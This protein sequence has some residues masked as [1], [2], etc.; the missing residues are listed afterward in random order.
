MAIRSP[1]GAL[2]L[3]VAGVLVPGFALAG[4]IS[5]SIA[6]TVEL[7]DG[8]LAATVQVSNSGDEAAHAVAPLLHFRDQEVR[9]TAREVLAP[10]ESMR[11]E[12]TLP[13]ADLGVGRWPYRLAVDYADGNQY[14]F[15]ALHLG[16]VAQGNVPPAK[17]GVLDLATEPLAGSGSVRMRVKNLSA[18]AR[19]VSLT[20]VLP[21]GVEVTDPI[22]HVALGPWE[23]TKISSSLVNR[24]ALAG[25]RY[26]IFVTAEYADEGVHEVALGNAILEVTNPRSFFQA[27]RSLLWIVA[28]VLVAGWLGFLGWQIANGRL[29]RATPPRR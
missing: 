3:G 7:R 18:T 14:P 5:I 9:G 6:P 20:I 25:S 15:Q 19:D 16:M 8:T 21:E 28:A 17:V 29:R 26:P 24:T 4:S 12:L 23:E 2:G 1:S 22:R 13:A 27:Q 11:A 10:K